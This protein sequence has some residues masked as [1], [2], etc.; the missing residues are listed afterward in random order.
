MMISF[1]Y[2][3]FNSYVTKH[4]NKSES[5]DPYSRYISGHLN[6]AHEYLSSMTLLAF[7]GSLALGF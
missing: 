4:L 5:K 7:M 2:T 6:H 3:T 1:S